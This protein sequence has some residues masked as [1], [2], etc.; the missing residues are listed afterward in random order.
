MLVPSYILSSFPYLV[1]NSKKFGFV[2]GG[3]NSVIEAL[4]TGV[5][6]SLAAANLTKNVNTNGW[7]KGPLIATIIKLS[8]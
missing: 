8:I 3:G 6:V 7:L 4:S 5:S 1:T 2:G